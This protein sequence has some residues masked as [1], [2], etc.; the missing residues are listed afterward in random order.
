MEDQGRI[1]L[2]SVILK[3][4]V[5]Q[6][7]FIS[8]GQYD[9]T[10]HE[11]MPEIIDDLIIR[12]ETLLADPETRGNILRW[13]Q[14]NIRLLL[15][16]GPASQN[17]ARFLSRM[18]GRQMDKPL[19]RILRSSGSD[20]AGALIRN[21][22]GRIKNTIP[23]EPGGENSGAVSLFTDFTGRLRERYGTETLYRVLSIG[24]EQKDAVDSLICD[25]VFRIADEQIGAALG[26]INVR[27]MVSERIDSLDMIRVERIILDVMAHQLKWIDVFGAL[28]GFLIGLFQALFSWFL[29]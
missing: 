26:A 2:A 27:A 25:T 21:F 7:L 19:G 14:E 4:N 22:F 8:T 1:F 29:R 10:L 23:P 11:R 9:K 18:L 5:F 16:E 13:G 17:A 28:L 24:P 6:R 12:L 20:D 15:S 3:L